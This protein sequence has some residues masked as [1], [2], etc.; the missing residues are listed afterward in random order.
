[1]QCIDCKVNVM[2]SVP[3]S[4]FVTGRCHKCNKIYETIMALKEEA[5]KLIEETD[6]LIEQVEKQEAAEQEE[7]MGRFG[8]MDFD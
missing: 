1:M 4:Y 5:E 6:K 2:G 7:E 8:M 3:S